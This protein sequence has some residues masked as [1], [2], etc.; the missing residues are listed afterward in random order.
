MQAAD[1]GLPYKNNSL[2][3]ENPPYDNSQEPA[4]Q[5]RPTS[6]PPEPLPEYDYGR[7]W[8]AFATWYDDGRHREACKPLDNRVA[9]AG[10]PNELKSISRV[11]GKLPKSP[12]FFLNM[13]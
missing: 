10:K 8:Y 13:N 12:G 3:V 11:Y 1:D 5:Q 7:D 4:A 9:A 2:G 6:P